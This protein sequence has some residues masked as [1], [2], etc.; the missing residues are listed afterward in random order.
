MS[1]QMWH[2]I[3]W[4]SSAQPSR[5]VSKMRLERW[6]EV[7]SRGK[8]RIR[9]P[10]S[11]ALND[12]SAKERR[13]QRATSSGGAAMLRRRRSARPIT[14]HCTAGSVL[15]HFFFYRLSAGTSSGPFF[16]RIPS[17]PFSP[18]SH[19]RHRN[20]APHPPCLSFYRVYLMV[21]TQVP[22]LSISFM[23]HP[24]DAPPPLPKLC[25]SCELCTV[26]RWPWA[27]FPLCFQLGAPP[28]VHV[29]SAAAEAL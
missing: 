29:P 6:L 3:S 24:D 25:P 8:T 14:C 28:S 27:S 19:A 7:R 1:H 12:S 16:V 11:A 23:W 18:T 2:P 9:Y 20:D 17:V 13:M 15:R 4:I 22:A 10:S 21:R 5:G 26:S